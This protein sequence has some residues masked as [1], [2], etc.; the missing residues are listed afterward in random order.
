MSEWKTGDTAPRT[1][2]LFLADVGWPWP[3]MAMWSESQ[4]EFCY[5]ATD[6]SV[7]EG[8]NDPVFVT[9][10]EKLENIK[11]WMPLPEVKNTKVTA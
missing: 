3:V 11:R 7:Y 6:A 8:K 9:E 4:E 5:A 1:G 10:W 2:Q